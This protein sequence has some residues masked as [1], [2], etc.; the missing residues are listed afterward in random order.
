LT[1]SPPSGYRWGVRIHGSSEEDGSTIAQFED[2][3]LWMYVPVD[4]LWPRVAARHPKLTAHPFA[5]FLNRSLGHPDPL[6]I[7]GLVSPI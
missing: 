4:E 3:C 6:R 2:F 1:N 7:E 5:V